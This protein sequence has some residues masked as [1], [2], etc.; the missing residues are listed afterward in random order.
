MNLASAEWRQLSPDELR[1]LRTIGDMLGIAIE[2]A[3]LIEGSLEAGAIEERNR[4]AREIHDTLAQGL[5]ATA[6]HL[7]AAEALLEGG[8][9]LERARAAVHQALQVTRQSLGE[10]RRSVFDLRAGPLEGRRL[11]VALAELCASAGPAGSEVEFRATGGARPLP[12]RVE[13]LC[14]GSG[15]RP[16]RTRSATPAPLAS[17]CDSTPCPTASRSPFVT[18]VRASRCAGGATDAT[19]W[20]VCVSA[21]GSWVANSAY[22]AAPARE[23]GLRPRSPSIGSPPPGPLSFQPEDRDH[24][25]HHGAD[26]EVPRQ[27]DLHQARRVEPYPGRCH[28]QET[29]AP[30]RLSRPT[31][32]AKRPTLALRPRL[33]PTAFLSPPSRPA[34]APL[35]LP[36]DAPAAPFH[37]VIRIY[38]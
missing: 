23:P 27:L 38:E 10:A 34:R 28:R 24:P 30:S 22:L 33:P 7:E 8:A 18:T 20:S 35:S 31:P 17:P 21:S 13:A 29:G 15:R 6:L 26:R 4:I 12:Q 9:D 3:R 25:L 5:S 36:L 11:A 2:R 16:S 37:L 14:T 32:S 1:I 19:A